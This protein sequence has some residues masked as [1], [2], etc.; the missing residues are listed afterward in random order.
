V[1]FGLLGQTPAQVWR[2][3]SGWELG[4]GAMPSTTCGEVGLTPDCR[5]GPLA[6][7]WRLLLARDFFAWC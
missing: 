1:L 5:L 2:L 6:L 4:Q 3:T 7:A